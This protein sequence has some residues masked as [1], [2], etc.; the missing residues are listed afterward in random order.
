MRQG[1]L[2]RSLRLQCA[3]PGHG[4]SSSAVGTSACSS[5]ARCNCRSVVDCSR[6]PSEYSRSL[7]L[8]TGRGRTTLRLLQPRQEGHRVWASS[9]PTRTSP[10]LASTSTTKRVSCLISPQIFLPA[11]GRPAFQ[12]ESL[13]LRLD[14]FVDSICVHHQLGRRKRCRQVPG[15]KS[16]DVDLRLLKRRIPH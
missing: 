8:A 12:H 15:T 9:R 10:A 6:P 11:P 1:Q 7:V 13:H 14:L 16:E 2:S 4:G 3:G 5:S